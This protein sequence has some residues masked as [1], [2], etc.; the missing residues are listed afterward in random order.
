MSQ[1]VEI[2][3]IFIN[4]FIELTKNHGVLV[5]LL[6]FLGAVSILSAIGNKAFTALKYLFMIFIAIPAIIV[7]GL[8]NKENRKERIKELGEI[9]AYLKEKPS[10]WKTILYYALFCLFVLFILYIAYWVVQ[11]IF[12]P[13]KELNEFSKVALQNHSSNITG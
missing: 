12:F 2:M 3:N 8:L 10:R 7:L 6:I 1:L 5:A 13:F 11:N 9:R 4:G